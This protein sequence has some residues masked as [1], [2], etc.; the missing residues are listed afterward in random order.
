MSRK[1]REIQ[2]IRETTDKNS[3]DY[4]KNEIILLKQV[5]FQEK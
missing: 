2:P 3:N 5:I 1:I 4:S